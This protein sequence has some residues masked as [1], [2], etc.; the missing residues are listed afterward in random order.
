MKA[1]LKSGD[2]DKIIFLAGVSREKEVYVMAAN[3]LQALDWRSNSQLL[4]TIIQFYSKAKAHS[5]LS[6]FYVACAN[7]ILF[8][9][10]FM[11]KPKKKKKKK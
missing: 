9:Y 11:R 7:V 3:Y 1:L 10:L 5:A 8:I 2:T 6:N 4:N